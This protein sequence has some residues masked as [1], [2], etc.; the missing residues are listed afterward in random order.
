MKNIRNLTDYTINI[1]IS[2]KPSYIQQTELEEIM[3]E[4]NHINNCSKQMK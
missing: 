3:S 2:Q 1:E 4:K